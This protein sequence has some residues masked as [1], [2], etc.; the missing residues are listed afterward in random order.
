MK[1]KQIIL[2]F[3]CVIFLLSG[4][5]LLLYSPMNAWLEEGRTGKRWRL[6]RV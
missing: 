1:R 6:F 3:L 2:S 5:G 4:L